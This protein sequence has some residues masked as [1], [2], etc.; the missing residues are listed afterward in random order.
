LQP[1][2]TSE[3]VPAAGPCLR[4]LLRIL[5]RIQR[6]RL[7]ATHRSHP[8]LQVVHRPCTSFQQCFE[9]SCVAGVLPCSDAPSTVSPPHGRV[10]PSALQCATARPQRRESVRS[11]SPRSLEA[12]HAHLRPCRLLV[13]S[14]DALSAVSSP[15][16][17]AGLLARFHA[18]VTARV[19]TRRFGSGM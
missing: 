16:G 19:G 18:A 4:P 6:R 2:V 15:L 1:H 9:P 8:A 10:G 12:H 7:P 3:A 14:R 17:A 5:L 13:E 11:R